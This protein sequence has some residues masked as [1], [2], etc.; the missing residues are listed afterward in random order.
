MDERIT[1]PPLEAREESHTCRVGPGRCDRIYTRNICAGAGREEERKLRLVQRVRTERVMMVED[2]LSKTALSMLGKATIAEKSVAFL[3]LG[4]YD[5]T[6]G[7][8]RGLGQ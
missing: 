8:L 5:I 4:T 1:V 3:A 2:G 7:A 6:E